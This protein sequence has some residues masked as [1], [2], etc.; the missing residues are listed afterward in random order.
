MLNDEKLEPFPLR[1]GTRQECSLLTLFFNI[2]LEVFANAIRQE[3][4]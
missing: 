3:R 1:S 2:I 4:K